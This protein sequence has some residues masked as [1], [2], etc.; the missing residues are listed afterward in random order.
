MTAASG[1][2]IVPLYAPPD[3]EEAFAAWG[4]SC[5]PAALAA[6][7][8]VPILPLREHFPRRYTNPTHMKAA[9]EALKLSWSSRQG[10]P[11]LGLAFLQIEG[12]WCNPGVPVGAAYQ[13]T[14]WIA[15]AQNAIYDINAGGWLLAADW[16]S[17]LMPE[18]V[19]ATPRATGGWY[20]REALEIAGAT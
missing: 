7:A 17:E 8:R 10:L 16:R 1:Q 15:V 18:I 14:H 19:K 4:A 13:R 5:G 2:G 12:S 20:V 6:I 3:V 11:R 9:V